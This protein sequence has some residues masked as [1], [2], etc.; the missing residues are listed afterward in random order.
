[1]DEQMIIT[2]YEFNSILKQ[3]CDGRY[4]CTNGDIAEFRIYDRGATL[5]DSM[6]YSI[7]RPKKEIILSFAR[8][9]IKSLSVENIIRILL[10]ELDRNNIK[11]S[12]I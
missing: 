3:L 2:I 6:S 4:L 5:F 10:I 11:I 1:M 8:D 9:S 12:N 7:E